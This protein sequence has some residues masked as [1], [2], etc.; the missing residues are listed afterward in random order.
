MGNSEGIQKRQLLKQLLAKVPLTNSAKDIAI[1]GVSGQY[2]MAETLDV[3]WDNLKEGKNCITE[4]PKDR[5]DWEGYYL[6]DSRE[7]GTSY[8]KWGGFIKDIDKFDPWFFQITPKEAEEMDPQERLFLQT[9]WAVLEDAGVTRESLT[10]ENEKVGVFVGV[11]NNFY[12]RHGG[13]SAYWSIANRIS[14]FFN[15]QGPSITVDTACSSSLT[16]IH[17]ACE[18]LKKGEC[19]TAIA[20]GVNL[21]VHPE[22]YNNLSQMNMLSKGEKC[23]AFGAEADGFV[24]GEGVGA[25]LLKTVEK[26]IADGD[27]IYA[28]IKGT[29]INAGG[30][31][32][33]YTVPNP[34]AQANLIKEALEN[35]QVDPATISY[36]EAH[37]TGTSLGDPIEIAGLTKAFQMKKY[38]P[39]F[40]A[41][42]SVKSNIGHLESAAGIAGLTK[43]LCQMKHKQLV[44]SLHSEQ[45]N[46]NIA[47]E[48]TPFYVQRKLSEWKQPI[49]ESNGKRKILPRRAS[50][51][52]FGAGGANAHLILEEH[53]ESSYSYHNEAYLILL[54]AKDKE[55]L[56]DY[57]Y[58]LQVFLERYAKPLNLADIAYTLQV[59]REE[60]EERLAIVTDNKESLQELLKQF[61]KGE[62]APDLYCSNVTKSQ[63]QQEMV[64]EYIKQNNVKGLAELWVCGAT[65]N[66]TNFYK[67]RKL[68]KISLP[69]YPFA[70]ERYWVA[71]KEENVTNQ[72]S[73]KLHPLIDRNVS[74]LGEQKFTLGLANQE[75]YI[76]D[77]KVF[78]KEILPGTIILEMARA[79]GNLSVD[80]TVR[81]IKN[82]IWNTPI[83]S[84]LDNQGFVLGD[85]AISLYSTEEGIDYEV[86]SSD[87]GIKKVLHARG[88]M[89]YELENTDEILD[90]KTIES[91]CKNIKD[92]EEC[93]HLFQRA[94]LN[95]GPSFQ[96][97]QRLY[98]SRSEALSALQLPAHLKESFSS[99]ELHPSLLDGALQTVMGLIVNV[100]GEQELTYLPVSLGEL[101]ILQPLNEKCYAY[102][103]W[104]EEQPAPKT[105]IKTFMIQLVNEVGQ[106]LVNIKDF[107]VAALQRKRSNTRE[108]EVA[109]L[110]GVWKKNELKHNVKYAKV[111]GNI[112]LFDTDNEMRNK[113]YEQS[114]CPEELKVILVKQGEQFNKLEGGAYQI[115]P[116]DPEDYERLFRFLKEENLM[117][118]YI[119]HL[120]AQNDF[121]KNLEK[122]LNQSVYSIFY[123]SQV[124]MA[125][126]L[127]DNISLVY[128]YPSL[129]GAVQP[130]Y[131]ALGALIKTIQLESS[132]LVAKTIEIDDSKMQSFQLSDLLFAELVMDN[133]KETEIKYDSNQRF[134]KVL[135]EWI[136]QEIN[137]PVAFRKN[138]VYIITGGTG[139]L[140]FLFAKHLAER[141]Q[142]KLILVGRSELNSEKEQQVRELE[143]LGAEVLYISADVSKQD[144]TAKL[145]KQVKG[146]FKH[147]HGVIHSAGVTRDAFVHKKTKKNMKDV[148]APKVY[149]TVWIDEYTKEE[150]L[151][152][153]ALFS[154]LAG[155]LGNVGQ[156]D[157]AYA[158]SFMDYFAILR[159]LKREKQQRF[160]KTLSINWPFWEQGGMKFDRDSQQWMENILG[161]VPLQTENGIRAFEEGLKN[162]VSQFIVLEG[163]KQKIMEGLK[164]RNARNVWVQDEKGLE[165]RERIQMQKQV[166]QYLKE[167]LSIETK[168]PVS[169]IIAEEPFEKY[170]I[171]SV[172]IMRMIHHLEKQFG[173]LSKTL[174]FEYQSIKELSNYFIKNHKQN[175]MDLFG[176]TFDNNLKTEH[177]YRQSISKSKYSQ[178]KFGKENDR[179][180]EIA[181]IGV[182]G[183]YPMADNLEEFWRVLKNGKD[184]ITEVPEDRW[185]YR[186]YFKAGEKTVGKSY[187]KWGGFINDI[188]KFDSLF[189]NISPR[190]AKLLDPQERLFLETVWHTL[191]DAGYKK[192]QLDNENVGVFVGVMYG[193]YQLFG[194]EEQVKGNFVLPNSS[195]A[196]IAN[197][198]S[199]YFNFHGPSIALDTMCSSSLTAIHLA[200]SSLQN[201]ESNLAIAGGVNI[202]VHPSKYLQLSEANFAS[203]DGRCRSFGEGGDGY[204]P[205]EGVGAV[206][207]KPLRQAVADGDH[208]YGVIKAS[209]LNHGG[210]TNGYTVPNPNAQGKLITEALAKAKVSASDISY[211]EA[212]GTGTSLGDPIE[213]TGLMQAYGKGNK[214]QF[215]SIGS[216]KSNIGHL[217]SAAGIAALTKVLLQMKYKQLV[218][219]IHSGKLNP[220]INFLNSPF[221]VQCSLEE[222]KQ[223]IDI[224]SGKEIKIPRIAGISSFGAGGA[225]AHLIV[226]EHHN[227]P[228]KMIVKDEPQVL[229][230]SAKNVEQLK[231]YA[232]NVA[233]FLEKNKPDIRAEKTALIVRIKQ[234][235]LN[236]LSEILHVEIEDI[237][238][239][240]SLTD[241]GVDLVKFTAFT[242]VINQTYHIKS[243]P[244]I[245]TEYLSL[246]DLSQQ[247][248]QDHR[249]ILNNYYQKK[250]PSEES[251]KGLR[252]SA[253]LSDIA[254]TF[255]VGREALEARMAI[256]ASSKEELKYKLIQFYEED[257]TA[258]N[259]Y[260]GNI[261]T[262]TKIMSLLSNEDRQSM[263]QKWIERR[264][265]SKLAEVWVNGIDIDWHKLSQGH[266]EKC[267][268]PVYPFK[269]ERHWIKRMKNRSI[270][271]VNSELTVMYP[272]IDKID[273]ELSLHTKGVVYKKKIKNN[274]SIVHDHKVQNQLILPG[275]AHLEMVLEA[276]QQ[277]KKKN[278]YSLSNVTWLQPIIVDGDEKEIHIVIKEDSGYLKYEIQ[279]FNDEQ[280]IIYSKGELILNKLS[281]IQEEE[282]VEIEKI[283]VRA[284]RQMN[285]QELYQS[286][287]KVGINYGGYFQGVEHIWGN[288]DEALGILRISDVFENGKELYTLHPTL[289]DG[290]LQTI[291][292]I[293]SS[294]NELKLPYAIGKVE[295]K[296]V[297]SESGYAYVRVAGKN[298]YNIMLL[299]ETGRVCIK[300]HEVTVRPL[301]RSIEV[302]EISHDFYY[303]PSW[304]PA[305]LT[306]QPESIV[307][308]K[309]LIIAPHESAGLADDLAKVHESSEVYYI[310]LGDEYKQH[311]QRSWEIKTDDPESFS[312]CMQQMYD[313]ELI[314]FLGGIQVE[315]AEIENLTKLNQSQEEGVL[316]LFRLLKALSE[317]GYSQ[318]RLELKVITNN[319]YQLMGDEITI[320]YSS[321]LHGLTKSMMKEYKNW[322]IHYIDI[323]LY[324]FINGTLLEEQNKIIQL[325]L[326]ESIE[327]KAEEVLL[328]NDR[329][330]VRSL[331]Q[332]LLPASEKSVFKY[333]GVYLILGGAGGIGLELSRYLVEQVDARIVLIGRSKLNAEKKEKIAKIESKGGK[334]CYLQ[335]D[336]TNL[337]SMKEAVRK[338]KTYFGNI[339]GV[340]H[341]AIVL[342]DCKLENMDEQTFRSVL[343]P[344]VQGSVILH[345]ALQ[346][347]VLDFMTFFSS[348]QS[349]VG[350][351]GQSNY[352]AACTFKDAF[353][354]Y[355]KQKESYPI[356]IMNWG[357][358]GSVGIVATKKYNERLAKQGIY[359]ISVEEGM[360]AVERLLSNPINQIMAMKADEK[361]LEK[362]GIDG[363]HSNVQHLKEM[364]AILDLTKKPVMNSASKQQMKKAFSQLKQLNRLLL[365]NAFQKM[366]VFY[367]NG[368]QYHIE[369]LSKQL[370]ITL[371]YT[372]L[373][374]ALLN[375]MARAGFITIEDSV[376]CTTTMVDNS[377]TKNKLQNLEQK[378]N[379]LIS[380]P[381]I[382]AH[383]NLLW[384]CF[385][386]YPDILR[387]N[388]AATDILFPESSME[389]VEGIYQKNASA[390]YFNQLVAWGLRS[391]IERRT[392]TMKDNEKIKILEIGAGTG[393]TSSVVFKEIHEYGDCLQYD[394]TDISPSFTKYGKKVYGAANPFVQF[395]LLNIEKDIKEQ[396]YIL[397][398][399]DVIIATNVLHAT[400]RLQHTLENIKMLLKTNGWIIIN[401]AT[402]VDDFATLTFG[403]LEGWW[404]YDD[405]E[406]RLP[407]SP[408]LSEEMWKQNLKQV[409]FEKIINLEPLEEGR[410]GLVQNIIIGESSGIIE[411]V[412][413]DLNK[414][415][416][417]KG[418]KFQ[419][420]QTS[421][422]VIQEVTV[423]QEN[424]VKPSRMTLEEQL[425]IVEEKILSDVASTLEINKTEIQLERPFSDYGVD[426][427]TG[428]ELIKNI[429]E[430][431][432]VALKT[433]VLFDYNNIKDLAA[434][435]Y[436]E[437]KEC[438]S[439]VFS[440]KFVKKEFDEDLDLL[441]RLVADELTVDEAYQ[442]MGWKYEERH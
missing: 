317:Q 415:F 380:V 227:Q 260:R 168:I 294:N 74:I 34:N 89:F 52:S 149:G 394:Y 300:L 119:L 191:E 95:Y 263:I 139:G 282:F 309:V 80:K 374:K 252:D 40:C 96:T 236:M 279:S 405:L 56:R 71:G 19:H 99:F 324:P 238:S 369:D 190:E 189:F 341:S 187:T 400:K 386:Y 247:L 271:T 311:S 156:A 325:I 211:V 245:C 280:C 36:V 142:A 432:G 232:S 13:N 288:N 41:I 214:K 336:A 297:L 337:A 3:F 85:V 130:Q 105:K 289:M 237:D 113:L 126:K 184:C 165:K 132:I 64:E 170:G 413:R 213:I 305:P 154:S 418:D 264:E 403:L 360:G 121:E 310:Q 46:P 389:L 292:G 393:G 220:N 32:S 339:N 371:S 388:I 1:I 115:N 144:E 407:D 410:N 268:V 193:Q 397:G 5:W 370:G 230:L 301:K 23:R 37:G 326:A 427:I 159:E 306:K 409:G 355:L 441:D 200:V 291:A 391:Y 134:V 181:I 135:Q 408:L 9:A 161:I 275:V 431:F 15:F 411:T 442:L 266:R 287:K 141:V 261:N 383:V 118:S 63:I 172:I 304:K 167:I 256:I 321:S 127:Q 199:Y 83:T 183:R 318:K 87:K 10:E 101:E 174:Y 399:Y 92:R 272:L 107:S 25:V 356:K 253:S 278:N 231:I 151:D 28:V 128:V 332:V 21:I 77:H 82:V 423:V 293:L 93:Y 42:G 98:L 416:I 435:I 164:N 51:S 381:E 133:T 250:V 217:E 146:R 303:K 219:S 129:Q 55:R 331:T 69:T 437:Y 29:S 16:A 11:M 329:R 420:H 208:I 299:D 111:S 169:R 436:H 68:K 18:S 100:E 395:K 50:I 249:E 428:L 53:E 274:D 254:Y 315:E 285:H 363:K 73:E 197:R 43:V 284:T 17:L 308:N 372:R 350:N 62:D 373:F 241:Y 178:E 26:A 352:A 313:I 334:V 319:V 188:D 414:Q 330:Y 57:A 368:E 215:C 114:E 244:M 223:P 58:N 314:Y 273:P 145:I 78:G 153:F 438:L 353:A 248:Y 229:V 143:N 171:D 38:K 320:P 384:V 422:Q 75:F 152:F 88:Q 359:S 349:F 298:R 429:N 258:E 338:A 242:D 406:M 160:G 196:S 70:K 137:E 185:D 343:N 162:H 255:Q 61:Y 419:A 35:A 296:R 240:E 33:G 277:V 212:H 163:K 22:H 48:E 366:G 328:R 79:A 8:S 116:E 45:L 378:R 316:S 109:Y 385:Q 335:A 430:T 342:Q 198:V 351:A 14:Y 345:Q 192:S 333:Q 175:L 94:N 147:I 362:I 390:D 233:E 243:D 224:K 176:V 66:W 195:Y 402:I 104:K 439:L 97:I 221:R 265:L 158:N 202:T 179:K 267:S 186:Q 354:H 155:E 281:D 348:A 322:N 276:L 106:V 81:V 59:G 47:F 39:A 239:N 340:I 235:L 30:K 67:E 262:K 398:Q 173:E 251:T 270:E 222:W 90:L 182:S 103:T 84:S 122:Q 150:K 365:L 392:E 140:G 412:K 387:G 204:V 124:I 396:G 225:N 27:H 91:R 131:A 246:E 344:K 286:F 4:V 218:P 209:T 433:T 201:G 166:E 177:V 125:Q 49:V 54:S 136:P 86:W 312:R 295:I 269:K 180:E 65:I 376:V 117:P 283:K 434:Y 290:A 364:T 307:A 120:W 228:E 323:D 440:D 425:H 377:N 379:D 60:M 421:K 123:L 6:P 102:V 361:V 24:D 426:S 112:L 210:K 207:L 327:N 347:E 76:K 259:I 44:P 12:T 31:T 110:H 203:S 358:W 367:Q 417:S 72:K 194:A 302:P 257:D 424:L 226:Q 20:G 108:S 382:N 206:L 2:P 234:D 138:G 7:Q 157:Y 216:V 205:G 404:L 148:L 375:I 357:Y 346:G 401:E